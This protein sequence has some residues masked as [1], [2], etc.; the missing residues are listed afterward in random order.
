VLSLLVVVVGESAPGSVERAIESVVVVR[1]GC[2]IWA[3]R[4]SSVLLGA[5]GLVSETSRTQFGGVLVDTSVVGALDAVG[6]CTDGGVAGETTS[7]TVGVVAVLSPLVV[8]G[9]SAARWTERALVSVAVMW[10]TS[11]APGGAGDWTDAGVAGEAFS[12]VVGVVVGESTA[13]WTERA[14]L[15]GEAGGGWADAVGRSLWSGKLSEGR[16]KSGPKE[17]RG[18]AGPGSF[19]LPLPLPLSLPPGRGAA[20]RPVRVS[21][22]RNA[23]ARSVDAELEGRRGALAPA[24][25]AAAAGAAGGVVENSAWSRDT[26]AP[27]VVRCPAIVTPRRRTVSGNPRAGSATPPPP[28]ARAR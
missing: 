11:G 16:A 26:I 5:L 13:G 6:G 24:A 10:A 18:A 17:G 21:A 12:L 23:I 7:A 14:V 3:R 27:G 20:I 15:T 2:D 8:V 1:V 22:S 28:P 4:L 19:P 25:A 9:E